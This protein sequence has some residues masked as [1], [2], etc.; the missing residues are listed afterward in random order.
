[1]SPAGACRLGGVL[2]TGAA[3]AL[4][5]PAPA[6]A[7]LVYSALVD[8]TWVVEWQVALGESPRPVAGGLSVDA[9]AAA[10]SPDGSRV[11]FEAPGLGIL[12]CPVEEKG[13][14]ETLK[15]DLGWPVRPTWNPKS[16]ELIFVRYVAD[17]SGEDSDILV[18]SPGL[19]AV[20][21][22]VRQTGNQDSPDIS[23]DGRFLV[24][25]SAQTVSLHRGGP[26]V[27]RHL[28][29]MDLETGAAR[30]LAPSS[31]QDMQPDVSPDG[32][33]VAFASDRAGGGF[34]IWVVGIDG[35]GLRQVT[36]GGGAKSWPA[37]SPDGTTI[38]YTSAH[39]GRTELWKTAADGS[40]S[41]NYQP[42]GP[43]SDAQLRD[44][45]WR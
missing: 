6:C 18:A 36:S 38:L 10:L 4:A 40:T 9:S 5:M 19:D 16:G 45:D 20:R 34:E 8:G 22:L 1:V 37:W 28:W 27:V 15:I 41:E 12:V 24:Y 29:V 2:A 35:E 26:Q 39:E 43:G 30:P 32:R 17:A 42:F 7:G 3:L 25:D 11:A 21:P 23:P 14:C 33:W 44:V 31:A 13:R